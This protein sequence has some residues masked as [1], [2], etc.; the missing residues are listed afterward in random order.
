MECS[1][2]LQPK[3]QLAKLP[4]TTSP[5]ET[6]QSHAPAERLAIIRCPRMQWVPEAMWFCK[7]VR[8]DA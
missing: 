3:R 2:L 7:R 1:N 8:I 4:K 6:L 5:P